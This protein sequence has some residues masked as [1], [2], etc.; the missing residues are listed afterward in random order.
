MVF[1]LGKV[2]VAIRFKL[3]QA[4]LRILQSSIVAVGVLRNPICEAKTHYVNVRDSLNTIHTTS[5]S[6]KNLADKLLIATVASSLVQVRSRFSLINIKGPPPTNKNSE[7]IFINGVYV[8]LYCHFWLWGV[9][10]LLLLCSRAG[11]CSCFCGVSFAC[12]C[13]CYCNRFCS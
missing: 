3:I 7:S 2:V 10:L 8:Y 12:F 1:G 11:F 6:I 13:S 9:V 5:G 4:V